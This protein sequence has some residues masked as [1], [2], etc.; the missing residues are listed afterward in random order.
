MA[1]G[2]VYDCL[3]TLHIGIPGTVATTVGMR[4]LDAESNA[5][6]TALTFSH[7]AAPPRFFVAKL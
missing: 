4:N 6:A 7:S 5:L 3:H 1:G 2:T